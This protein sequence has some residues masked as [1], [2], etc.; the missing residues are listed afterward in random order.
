MVDH[1]TP[2]TTQEL[3]QASVS[4]RAQASRDARLLQFEDLVSGHTLSTELLTGRRQT[5]MPGGGSSPFRR[6][7]TAGEAGF[8]GGG[9]TQETRRTSNTGTKAVED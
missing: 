9:Y 1:S 7:K 3:L 4:E 8:P 2:K 5:I 6:Q